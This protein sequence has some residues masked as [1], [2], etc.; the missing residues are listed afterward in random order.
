[1]TAPTKPRGFTDETIAQL[2]AERDE[3]AWAVARRRAAWQAYQAIPMPTRQDEEWR[4]T[5]LRSLEMDK[6]S[7][8]GEPARQVAVR[9]ALGPHADLAGHLTLVDGAVADTWISDEARRQGVVLADLR[10]ALTSYGDMVERLLMT[11]AVPVDDSKFAALHSAFW[12][13]GPFV[14]VPKGVALTRPIGV[15]IVSATPGR[16]SLSHT[17]VVLDEG[18]EALF[19]EELLGGDTRDQ[20]F[21][22]RAIEIIAGDGATLRFLSVQRFGETMYDFYTTRALLGRDA[23]LT[24]STVELGARLSK[25]RV[26]A[27]LRGNGANARLLGLYLGD[28]EQHYDRFTLQ[29]HTGTDT[30]SDLLYKGVLTDKARSVY[31]GFIRMHHGA[32][33]SRAYQQNRNVLLS[34][35]ARADS[36]PN[37]EISENDILGCTHGAT[38]GKV[39]A[40]QLFYLMC[41]GLTRTVATQLLVEGFIEPIIEVIAP[42]AL[43][44]SVRDEISARV[45]VTTAQMADDED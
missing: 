12:D 1:M 25:G 40:E 18:S 10:S 23:N 14:Y 43:Q 31:S 41:R 34:R 17:L 22:S 26:E 11:Q 19:A 6:A 4:R 9:P 21:S 20:A 13:N 27:M 39:D 44:Q 24:L 42:Q 38:V 16:A 7:P 37:L 32:R 33:R 30:S 8:L 35:T 2:I 15:T 28:R 5:D 36:I 3:P 29:D 45:A